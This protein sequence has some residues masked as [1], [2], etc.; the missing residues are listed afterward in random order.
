MIKDFVTSDAPDPVRAVSS[1]TTNARED[2]IALRGNWVLD[3]DLF[4][5]HYDVKNMKATDPLSK[6][7]I[8]AVRREH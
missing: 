3:V 7:S 4:F 8:N 1:Y 5:K 6:K 2:L